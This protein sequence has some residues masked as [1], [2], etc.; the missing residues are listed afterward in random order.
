MELAFI[1]KAPTV[2]KQRSLAQEFQTLVVLAE[3]DIEA[4]F[5]SVLRFL[6]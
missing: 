5:L 2:H 6:D 4:V 1:K 3:I